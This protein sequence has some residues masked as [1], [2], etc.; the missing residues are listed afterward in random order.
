MYVI[1]PET[2]VIIFINNNLINFHAIYGNGPEIQTETNFIWAVI[3][4]IN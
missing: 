1:G 3:L 2:F 4:L